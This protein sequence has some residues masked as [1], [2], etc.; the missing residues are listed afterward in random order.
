MRDTIADAERS[1]LDLSYLFIAEQH[2][3][4]RTIADRRHEFLKAIRPRGHKEL[5]EAIRLLPKGSGSRFRRAA[6]RVAQEVAKRHLLPWLA[7]EEV[8]GEKAFGA[9]VQRF[10]D[11]GNEFLQ[12][13]ALAGI[14]ELGDIPHPLE[15]EQGFR[16]RSR[17]YFYDFIEIARPA[18][19]LRFMA[20]LAIGLFGAH[21]SIVGDAHGFLD[22]LLDTNA[23]RVQGDVDKRIGDSKSR[24]EADIRVL[25]HEVRAVAERALERA[26]TAQSQGASAIE[27]ALA[28]LS[29][30]EREIRQLRP[31]KMVTP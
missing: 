16:A 26:R 25:L 1:V 21:A 12:R 13:L 2:R 23:T 19:P 5:A 17:F 27:N 6:M 30:I 7:A 14:P 3:L 10:V 24:L 29:A 9:A 28:K 15:A 20:D 22:H 31:G 18:S 4:S 8:L 11:L